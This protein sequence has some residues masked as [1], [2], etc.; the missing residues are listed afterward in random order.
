ML[1]AQVSTDVLVLVAAIGAGATIAGAIVGAV[2]VTSVSRRQQ[3]LSAERDRIDRE[4]RTR[5]QQVYY[6]RGVADEV[7]SALNEC[8]NLVSDLRRQRIA[9]RSFNRRIEA[10]SQGESTESPAESANR[11]QSR[12]ELMQRGNVVLSE[13]LLITHA[14]SALHPKAIGVVERI[15]EPQVRDSCIHAFHAVAAYNH[16]VSA[17][18]D[19]APAHSAAES[20]MTDS[21]RRLGVWSRT[22]HEEPDRAT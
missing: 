11:L 3:S 20:S 7:A 1:A 12:T 8:W 21:Q 2:A 4:Q 9:D 10:A 14:L 6:A 5:E 16:A 17:D 13:M 22:L 19:D 18:C 15:S